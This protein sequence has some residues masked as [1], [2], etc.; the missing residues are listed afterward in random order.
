MK[1][2]PFFGKCGGCKFD[3]AAADYRDRKSALLHSLPTTAAP[4]WVPA[5]P[6]RRADFCFA[7]GHFGMYAALSKDV[8]PVRECPNLLPEINA[9]L[10]DIA[11]LP[12]GGAGA[13]SCLITA[14]ENGMD[15][16]I[17]SNVPY[18]TS[19]FRTAVA[20]LPLIRVT[21]NGRTVMERAVPVVTFDDM[22][23]PYPSGAFLQPGRVGAD[24]LRRMVA[25]A[26]SGARRCADLFCGL[27]NFTYALN[28]DGFDIVGCGVTRDL[29]KNP[30]TLGML[31]QYDCVVMDP[32]RAGAMAQSK[33]LALSDVRRVIYVSCNPATFRRDAEILTHGGYKMTTLVPVDQFVGSAHWEL[34]SV[35]EK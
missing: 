13:G 28:A 17:T 32:P 30:L 12:W 22:T 16:A 19:E 10:P 5:G 6:R 7:A 27:G 4:V 18:C 29:F 21:W 25:A 34:F 15:V 3:F 2:C 33:I 9:V 31:K 20:R 1:T 11:A 26:A 23:V 35:F 24:E 8:I 14:C